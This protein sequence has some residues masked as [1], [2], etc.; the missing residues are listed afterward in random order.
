MLWGLGWIG[1]VWLSDIPPDVNQAVEGDPLLQVKLAADTVRESTTNSLK[2][3]SRTE[4]GA[5]LPAW[6][7]LVSSLSQ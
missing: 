2:K 4:N 5:Y 7:T 3:G 1:G 6:L